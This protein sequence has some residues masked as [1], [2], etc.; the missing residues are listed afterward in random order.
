MTRA[1]IIET[2]RLITAFPDGIWGPKSI[3]AAQKYLRDLMPKENP[4][5]RRIHAAAFYGNPGDTTQHTQ[6]DVTGLGVQYDRQAVTRIT[7][8]KQ[9]ADSLLRI[10]QR[11]ATF[12]E[13]QLAL[14]RYAGV[15]NN[16]SIRGGTATSIHAYA[17]AIDLAP[18]TNANHTHWPTV[19]TMSIKVMA[20]F[21]K[22]GWLPAGAFW[23]RDAMHF[24]AIKHF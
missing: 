6:I 11:L 20:E 7:V 3:A 21:A 13:G 8:N 23:H 14:A 22:E 16:R 1:E 4:W 9:C 10:I 5:P 18:A 19:A 17:A 15:Y 24:E 2:Q 12:P